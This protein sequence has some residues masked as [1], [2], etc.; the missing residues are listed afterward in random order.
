MKQK[1]NLLSPERRV[2]RLV[3]SRLVLL[4]IG[5]VLFVLSLVGG[6]LWQQ[7]L[8]LEKTV[9]Q[10][11]ETQKSLEPVRLRQQEIGRL[12][13]E[14][15]RKQQLYSTWMQQDVSKSDLLTAI[16]GAMP[17]SVWLSE[18]QQQ[19]KDGL[20]VL[21]GFSLTMDEVSRLVD[22]LTTL[23]GCAG[24]ELKDVSRDKKQMLQFEILLKYKR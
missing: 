4:E 19:E 18:I 16:A 15:Q 3:F 2:S 23:P 14:N 5:V 17:P 11:E 9:S 24:A 6:A 20:V 22:Q 12:R 7:N 13:Q 8:L 10:L 21:K 1:I